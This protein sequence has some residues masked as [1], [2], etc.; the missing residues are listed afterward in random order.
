MSATPEAPQAPADW[1]YIAEMYSAELQFERTGEGEGYID[2]I[3]LYIS[4]A[5]FDDTEAAIGLYAA[6]VA[7]PDSAVR[8][9]ALDDLDKLRVLAPT[10]A[11]Q[12][13][14][15][16]MSDEDPEVKRSAYHIATQFG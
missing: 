10:E 6:L 11:A 16:L 7:S 12:L 3:R 4:E 15:T 1:K 5:V 14:E 9:T 13:L 8:Q 2:P